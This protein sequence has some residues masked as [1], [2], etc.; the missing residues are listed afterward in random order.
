MKWPLFAVLALVLSGCAYAS[1]QVATSPLPIASSP[2]NTPTIRFSTQE[3]SPLPTASVAPFVATQPRATPV[4]TPCL[5]ANNESALTLAALQNAKYRLDAYSKNESV[6]LID[7]VY[8]RPGTP[9]QDNY[10]KLNGPIAYGDLNGDGRGDAAVILRDWEGGTGIFVNLAV[11]IDR[12][13]TPYNV[14]TGFLGDRVQI[15]SSCI[16]S[17]TITLNMLVAEPNEGF[18]CPTQQIIGSWKLVNNELVRTP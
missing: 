5:S 9:A 16:L 18:C 10:I 17:G 3:G 1:S 14:S 7:G 2:L 6:Q 11:V 12:D 4:I 15:L 8:H 13:G